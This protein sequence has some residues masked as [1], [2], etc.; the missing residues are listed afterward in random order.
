MEFPGERL[1]IRLWETIAEKGVA[2]LV[3]PWQIRRE[4]RAQIDIRRAE[5][6]ALA[7]AERDAEDI[8]SGRKAIVRC[9]RSS[10]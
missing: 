2:S 3:R 5:V 9:W 1:V 7:Q 6:V 4:G 8:R 10:Q